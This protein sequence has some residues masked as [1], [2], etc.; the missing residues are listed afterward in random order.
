[1]KLSLRALIP[2]LVFVVLAAF[3]YAGLDLNPRKVPSVL[4]GKPAPDFSAPQLRDPGAQFSPAQMRGQVWLLNVWA[5]WCV[6]CRQEHPIMMD[7]SRRGL[8]P[9]VGL[10]YKDDPVNAIAWLNDLGD[11][12]VVNI[13][14][15]DGR[16]GIDYGV[17]G[18]PET[19]VIDQQG[20]IRYKEIGPVTVE[21]L[22]DKIIP[23]IKE[24]QG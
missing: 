7:F 12:Y 6:P 16:I 1:M 4:I 9:V 22:R 11:P 8:A 23:L 2:L 15:T 13:T 17:Y 10:N 24:L 21:S 18:V 3:L 14:S 19:Y 5:S 20:V